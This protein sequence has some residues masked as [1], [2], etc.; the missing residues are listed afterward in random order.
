MAEVREIEQ[1]IVKRQCTKMKADTLPTDVLEPDWMFAPNAQCFPDHTSSTH[2][3][4]AYAY[5]EDSEAE[6]ALRQVIVAKLEEEAHPDL[7][8]KDTFYG[9]LETANLR[10]MIIDWGQQLNMSP[11]TLQSRLQ[12]FNRVITF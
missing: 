8:V 12:L 2:S 1:K 10:R 7:I 9:G 5:K 11:A 4:T 6:D 3:S